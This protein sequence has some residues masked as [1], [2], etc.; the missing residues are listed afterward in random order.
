MK[1]QNEQEMEVKTKK[2]KLVLELELPDEE[3]EQ[4]QAIA[5]VAGLTVDELIKQFIND[6]VVGEDH[7]RREIMRYA[8]NWIIAN[9]YGNYLERTKVKG[10]NTEDLSGKGRE[11]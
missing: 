1:K 4:I 6:V 3:V 7:N 10:R 11:Q 8:V 9:W 2:R 5:F